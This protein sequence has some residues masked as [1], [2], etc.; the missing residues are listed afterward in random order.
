MPLMIPF[1][2]GLQLRDRAG[3]RVVRFL[4]AAL[5]RRGREVMVVHAAEKQL[6][7]LDRMYEES[8][9][10]RRRRSSKTWRSSIA[11]PTVCLRPSLPVPSTAIFDRPLP[12]YARF[13][14]ART[15][16]RGD[17]GFESP[18]SLRDPP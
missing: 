8:P 18:G 12:R 6:P 16:Q 7:L 5:R 11:T 2:Y 9:Q 15:G 4:D 14:V 13:A 10:A 17:P 1:L 3:I